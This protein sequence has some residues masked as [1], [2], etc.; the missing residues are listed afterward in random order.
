MKNFN[1]KL[2]VFIGLLV[3]MLYWTSIALF[4]VI[5][6]G[7]TWDMALVV[8]TGAFLSFEM[9]ILVGVIISKLKSQ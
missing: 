9:V 3:L 8:G 2:Y 7:L 5:F 6:T 4:P 1:F